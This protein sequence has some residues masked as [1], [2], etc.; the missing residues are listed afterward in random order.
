M[1]RQ[2][3]VAGTNS[4]EAGGIKNVAGNIPNV[5]GRQIIEGKFRGE[6]I[7]HHFPCNGMS[8]T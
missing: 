2:R 3:N 8:T 5:A 4:N 1:R 7:F 6:T